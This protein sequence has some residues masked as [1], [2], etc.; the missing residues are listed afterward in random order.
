MISSLNNGTYDTVYFLDETN[1][2]SGAI[3]KYS[4]Q[5]D[6]VSWTANGSWPTTNGGDG[7]CAAANGSG[8]AYLY[9]T[10]GAGGTAGNSLVQLDDSAGYNAAINITGTNVIFTAA[11]TAT[12]K[13]LA[14]APWPFLSRPR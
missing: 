13:G 8:G 10:T 6:G 2:T 14:F 5:E 7:F 3:Y 11:P 4:L 9:Y 12:L 1:K